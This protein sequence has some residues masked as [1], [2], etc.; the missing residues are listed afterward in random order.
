[1]C[2][3]LSWSEGDMWRIGGRGGESR[4]L[5]S[6]TGALLDDLRSLLDCST[7]Y[8]LRAPLLGQTR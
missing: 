6:S 1:M 3:G 8:L 5:R 2:A 4:N 7:T